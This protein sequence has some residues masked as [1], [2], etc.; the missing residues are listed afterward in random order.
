MSYPL[1]TPSVSSSS[2]VT[3]V[4][5]AR[6]R[7]RLSK[8][9]GYFATGTVT[10]R[11]SSLEAE[12][13]VIAA[14]LKSDQVP[15]EHFDE[16]FLYVTSGD[17]AGQQRRLV[18]GAFDGPNGALRVDAAF[19]AALAADTTF[20]IAVVPAVRCL[21]IGGTNEAINWS[22]ETL[23]IVDVVPVV[24]DGTRRVTVSQYTWPVKGVQGVYRPISVSDERLCLTSQRATFV[25]DAESPYVQLDCAVTSGTT[26][27]LGLLR[28]ASTRIQQND[29]WGDSTS[30]LVNDSDAALYDEAT[31]VTQAR[32]E[33]LR[34][35]AMTH[36]RGSAQRNDILAEA[37]DAMRRA[38]LSKWYGR[39]RESTALRVG[40]I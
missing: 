30:G 15:P 22:L 40:A 12:K 4:S 17:Q 13:F 39:F 36:P 25:N 28:P 11:T 6:Y 33:A 7:N 29:V 21:G 2:T 32:P 5:L 10:T 8:T 31:V 38:A 35:M 9:L 27:Y 1:I 26:F 16:L 3:G 37:E 19:T 18:D 34:R 24:S 14:T 23:P 20:E